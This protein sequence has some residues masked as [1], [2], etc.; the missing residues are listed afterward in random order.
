MQKTIALHYLTVDKLVNPSPLKHLAW[1]II[2]ELSIVSTD[3]IS[4]YLY[5]RFRYIAFYIRDT[6]LSISLQ[7]HVCLALLHQCAT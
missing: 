6:F 2:E 5:I 7:R 1:L 3:L 4:I